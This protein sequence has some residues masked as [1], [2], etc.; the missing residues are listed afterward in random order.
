MAIDYLARGGTEN[1]FDLGCKNPRS[2]REVISA[3]EKASGVKILTV[4]NERRKGD[5]VS[6]CADLDRTEHL[7]GWKPE[8]TF[9]DIVNSAFAWEKRHKKRKSPK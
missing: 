6:T 4:N 7:L 3:V 9:D 5:A 2:V 1:M 8:Y